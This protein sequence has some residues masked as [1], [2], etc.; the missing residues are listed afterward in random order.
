MLSFLC[1]EDIPYLTRC[2]AVQSVLEPLGSR[3]LWFCFFS[4]LFRLHAG[5]PALK[6]LLLST[7]SKSK[8]CCIY[9]FILCLRKYSQDFLVLYHGISHLLHVPVFSWYTPSPTIIFHIKVFLLTHVPGLL[10]VVSFNVQIR[11][12]RVSVNCVET[13]DRTYAMPS[14][15]QGTLG[16][17]VW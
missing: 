3:N 2:I 11:Y 10:K 4:V 14:K 1:G 5:I 9:V 7:S 8:I 15:S 13:T 16:I 12:S 17:I 6:A